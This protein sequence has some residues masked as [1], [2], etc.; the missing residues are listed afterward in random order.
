[1]RTKLRLFIVSC[2]SLF[3]ISGCGI[4]KFNA[5]SIP[6]EAET[7]SIKTIENRAR[8]VE[9]TLSQI[10]TDALRDRFTNQTRLNLVSRDGDLQFEGEIT[11]Y[12]TRP[13]AFQGGDIQ[14][15]A[16]NR[17]TI[18]V[19][20]RFVNLYNESANFETTF[21]RYEDYASSKNLIDVQAGLIESITEALV[22]DIFN[23]SVV[24]W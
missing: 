7:V 11:E 16:L 3:F 19:K 2:I 18:S 14:Q 20:I 6:A 9:P 15:G 23:A 1:M 21:S 8:L 24:N 5:A 17:L 13:T 12:H 22:E 4:Y 10:L